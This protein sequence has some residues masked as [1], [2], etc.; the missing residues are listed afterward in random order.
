MLPVLGAEG[1]P[2]GAR[3]MVRL[4]EIDDITLEI[5]GTVTERLD[6]A[7]ESADELAEEAEEDEALAAPLALAID[8]NEAEAPAPAAP[9]DNG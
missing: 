1:L 6:E 4:G 7:P 3:V 5:S 9:A 2:R 8:V